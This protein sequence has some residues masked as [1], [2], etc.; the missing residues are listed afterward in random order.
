[1][2]NDNR[3]ARLSMFIPRDIHKALKQ[4]A[5]DNN[6]TLTKVVLRALI[7][8]IRQERDLK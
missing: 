5:L 6:M 3:A 7:H 8:R 4:I 1:M 2:E